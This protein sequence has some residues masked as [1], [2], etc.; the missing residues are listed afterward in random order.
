MNNVAGPARA[1]LAALLA[2]A[3]LAAC[4][5]P[6]TRTEGAFLSGRM[7]VQVEAVPPDE[8]ARSMS[9]HF[10]LSGSALQG[11]LDLSTPLGTRVGAAR[12][13]PGAALL[14]GPGGRETAYPD[15]EAMT[16]ALLGEALPV[17]ALFDWLAGRPWPAAP[18]EAAQATSPPSFRQLGWLVD[19]ARFDEGLIVARRE[20]PPA[21]SVRVKLDAALRQ[22]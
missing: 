16:R 11:R 5:T 6:A 22:D 10:E 14:V 2:A 13:S 20:A 17:A 9:A 19:L 8:P 7:S 15:L 1:R 4:A 21:V 12:W 18:G 3:A